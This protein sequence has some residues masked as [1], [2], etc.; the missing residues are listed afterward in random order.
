MNQTTSIQSVNLIS[1]I[2]EGEMSVPGLTVDALCNVKKDYNT[3][4]QGKNKV[5]YRSHGAC[6]GPLLL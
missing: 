4:L 3:N 1:E 5:M 2:S 6:S